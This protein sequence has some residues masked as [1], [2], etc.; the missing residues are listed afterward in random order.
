MEPVVAKFSSHT[1]AAA[2]DRAYCQS[3]TPKQRLDIM[4][5][6]IA[7]Q[8]GTDEASQRF[9]RVCRIVKLREQ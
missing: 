3:L 8:R 9:A 2:A 7:S 4:L 6:L 5:E 1:Q